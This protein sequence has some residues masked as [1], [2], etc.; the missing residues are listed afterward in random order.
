MDRRD[1]DPGFDLRSDECPMAVFRVGFET[2]QAEAAAP[3]DEIDED[4]EI[5]LCLRSLQV[6]AIDVAEH[7]VTPRPGGGPPLGRGSQSTEV[8]VPDA[9]VRKVAGESGLG[10]P[11]SAGVRDGTDVDDRVD[12]LVS[13]SV[14][15]PVDRRRF[16]SDRREVHGTSKLRARYG[17][18]FFW[19]VHSGSVQNP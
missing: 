8:K 1:A 11:G 17:M 16:V 9:G 15:Q 13:Q 7:L 4:R 19:I 5:V 10:E 6:T 14:D 3:R 18:F 2:Q 12:P